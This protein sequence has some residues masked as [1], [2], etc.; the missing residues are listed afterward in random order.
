MTNQYLSVT[1]HLQSTLT[2]YKQ[3]I[4]TLAQK[5][6]AETQLLLPKITTGFMCTWNHS[7]GNTGRSEE[8]CVLLMERVNSPQEA[9]DQT[10]LLDDVEKQ[11]A[12]S[13]EW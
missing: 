12:H 11:M 1:L 7:E 13:F 6:D 5:S 10:L 8:A 2:A 4:W 9:A 3:I